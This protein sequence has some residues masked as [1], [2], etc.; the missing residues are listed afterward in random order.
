[1]TLAIKHRFNSAKSDGSD[2]SLVQ[3]SAWNDTHQMTLANNRLIG[4]FSGSA[5][6][7]TEVTVDT[8]LD[9][10]A[11]TPAQG[12]IIYR[13]GSAYARL[14]AGTSTQF[15]KGGTSPSWYTPVAADVNSWL[16]YTPVNP[17]SAVTFGSTVTLNADPASAL[18]AATKQYVDGLIQGVKHKPTARLATTAALPSNTYA[19]GTS[20]V[21]ATLTAT[22]N[23]ALTVD[24]VAVA[25]NDLILVLNEATAARNG[26]Y[27]VTQA[28]D[29]THPYILTRD[30]SMDVAAE[31]T[32]ALVPV[33]NEG[34]TNSNSLWL[35][36]S[37]AITVGTTAVNFVELNKAADLTAGTGISISGKTVSVSTS[38]AL[39]I[40]G[41]TR[42][43]LLYRGASGWTLL[44]PGTSG[45]LLQTNGAGADPSFVAPPS[46][47]GGF[48]AAPS[49]ITS[50][51]TVT[52]PA[53]TT[54]ARVWVIGGGAG[55]QHYAGGGGGGC[56]YKYLTGL[57]AGNTFTAT[58]GAAGA[59]TP[60]AG[61][62]TTLASGTQTISTLTG[63]GGAIGTAGG[64]CVSPVGGLGG[65]ASGGDLNMKGQTGG[66]INSAQT[67]VGGM[68]GGPFA[69]GDGSLG[70]G[71]DSR[72]ASNRAGGAGLI[73]IE[74]YA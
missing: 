11:G 35:C 25:A 67:A 7:A 70:S 40:I 37:T 34:T 24:G 66:T 50:S 1:M 71:G 55:S 31:F 49:V 39:D 23:G 64:C 54:K 46:T 9:A 61:G 74:W 52:I 8:A 21:G 41:S 19:N 15:M 12:D 10:V 47:G 28:G 58:I 36:N 32:G 18:H 43:S 48:S 69:G 17:G 38:A 3:P 59:A 33:D 60:T 44:A 73:Y 5:G 13:S 57:T 68:A 2:S 27:L 72:S 22:A 62:N 29:S 45:Y 65:S 14:P 16:G 26:L 4:N 42:G 53:G 63:N 6:D 51:Q 56:A 20:G 30:V